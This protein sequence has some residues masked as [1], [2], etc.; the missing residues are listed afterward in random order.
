MYEETMVKKT[1]GGRGAPWEFNLRDLFRWC[2]LLKANQ[3]RL[4]GILLFY[5]VVFCICLDCRCVFISGEVYLSVLP[6]L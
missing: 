6:I 5:F 1:W 3:V 2:D 4:I